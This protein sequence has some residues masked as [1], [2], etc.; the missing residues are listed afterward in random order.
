MVIPFRFPIPS[1]LKAF[2]LLSTCVDPSLELTLNL[3]LTHSHS[4]VFK[5]CAALKVVKTY[6][7]AKRN[8]GIQLKIIV[9]DF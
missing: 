3:L 4:D 5:Q 6:I 1:S 9:D 2:Q 8:Q 7:L